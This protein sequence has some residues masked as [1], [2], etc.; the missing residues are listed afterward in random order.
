[1]QQYDI[2]YNQPTDNFYR[3]VKIGLPTS[4]LPC[5]LASHRIDNSEIGYITTQN[6]QRKSLKTTQLNMTD[7]FLVHP[8]ATFSTRGRLQRNAVVVL[9]FAFVCA[10]F[11]ST[12]Q[13]LASAST[14]SRADEHHKVKVW[15]PNSS[16]FEAY[17]LEYAPISCFKQLMKYFDYLSMTQ[18]ITPLSESDLSRFDLFPLD[19]NIK[20]RVL[21][22]GETLCVAHADAGTTCPRQVALIDPLISREGESAQ[23]T[24]PL[25]SNAI[26]M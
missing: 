2:W 19:S 10:V 12:H 5:V 9:T 11:L 16:H 7:S 13:I 1:M 20:G 8:A 22:A 6:S 3:Y 4:T 15:S 24:Y 21:S 18:L 26:A 14:S 25:L 23:Y 17:E